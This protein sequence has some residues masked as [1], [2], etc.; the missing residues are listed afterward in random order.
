MLITAALPRNIKPHL[1]C[2]QH[3]SL[4]YPCEHNYSQSVVATAVHYLPNPHAKWFPE[5]TNAIRSEGLRWYHHVIERA[6][7]VKGAG[8]RVLKS[9]QNDLVS[10]SSGPDIPLRVVQSSRSDQPVASFTNGALPVDT[11]HIVEHKIYL[12]KR[13]ASY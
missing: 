4:S 9:A 10:T 2:P 1:F 12:K 13:S 5:T 3:V 6:V 8:K 7:Y 11:E